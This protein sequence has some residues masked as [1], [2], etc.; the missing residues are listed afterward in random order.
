MY[1]V[2]LCGGTGS[3]LW[4]MSREAHP[5]P[6][7]PLLGERTLLQVTVSRLTPNIAPGDV[8]VVTHEQYAALARAQLP[9]MPP[10]HV[11]AEPSARNTAAA[12]TLAALAVER[13]D[14]EVMV[15]LPADH[16]I[17]DEQGF[18]DALAVAEAGAR[19]GA[20]VTLG[21]A[22][23]APEPGYG[24]VVAKPSAGSGSD[25]SRPRPVAR[26]VEKPPV[27]QAR[28]LLAGGS[29]FWNGG[30]FVWRRD[31]LLD[32]LERHARYVVEPIRDAIHGGRSLA[33]AYAA[34]PATSIDYALLEPA[35][36]E[37]IV[38]VVPMDVGWS[39]LGSWAALM[40]ALVDSTASSVVTRGDTLD[41]GSTSLLV[42]SETGRLVVTIGLDGVVVIDT[43]DVVLVCAA[44][45]AQDVKQAVD[46]LAARGRRELL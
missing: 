26:F 17:E 41:V 33:D 32:G 3:R 37:G 44:G 30:I 5:K 39:D 13:P 18:R 20:L 36:L 1:A 35:S 8:Y 23:T 10:H 34:V 31:R 19:G 11:L 9:E 2:I 24:Y 25:G 45:R 14:D 21:I 6:F 15:V 27:E 4:P 28:E 22:P 12:V 42:E 16:R 29:A 38:G 43:P 46:I 7:L 40:D